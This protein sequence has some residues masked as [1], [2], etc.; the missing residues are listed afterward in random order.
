MTFQIQVS[1][2]PSANPPVTCSPA[3]MDMPQGVN[4]IQWVLAP[5]QKG[6][7]A[8]IVWQGDPPP[9]TQ[10]PSLE[11]NWTA[12]DDNANP[13]SSAQIYSY[14]AGVTITYASDP[15]IANEPG[16]TGTAGAHALVYG[17]NVASAETPSE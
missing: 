9:F 14:V 5:G 4:E 13:T 17:G 15:E 2:D 11:N 1:C 8:F 7:I 3:Q 6:Q 10:Y 12:I 16:T